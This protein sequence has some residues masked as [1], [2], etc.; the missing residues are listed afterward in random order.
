M[1]HHHA[2]LLAVFR[3][4][5]HT[6]LDRLEGRAQ[7]ACLAIEH[8]MPLDVLC[9]TGKGAHQLGPPGADHPGNAEHFT[10]AYAEVD[11]VQGKLA[12][13]QILDLQHHA[14]LRRLQRRENSLQAAPDHLLHQFPHWH[15]R[16]GMQGD[17]ATV[18]QHQHTVGDARDFF[19]AMADIDE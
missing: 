6:G 10:G 12:A 7:L 17:L 16:R 19:Q 5:H 15:L 18:A 3:Y 13:G 2:L 8:H 1:L 14:L 9:R 11:A 4:Q